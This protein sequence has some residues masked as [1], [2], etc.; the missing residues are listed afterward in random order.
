MRIVADAP[1]PANASA[2]PDA[3]RVFTE[4]AVGR[5]ADWADASWAREHSRVWQTAGR[6]G[7][8]LRTLL[9]QACRVPADRSAAHGCA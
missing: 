3:V 2:P 7:Y 9:R 8:A 1:L 5:I 6:T 4:Q